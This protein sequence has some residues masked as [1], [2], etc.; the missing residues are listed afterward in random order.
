MADHR[1]IAATVK[2]WLADRIHYDYCSMRIK[3]DDED[4][5]KEYILHAHF[6]VCG[7]CDGRGSVVNPS[8]DERGLTQEDFDEDPDFRV[9]YCRGRYDVPC[10][11]CAGRNVVLV[12]DDENDPAALEAYQRIVEGAWQGAAEEAREREMG[13]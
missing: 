13:Y 4:A 10:P 3:V 6:D 1:R 12:P 5:D 7:T 11:E 9:E 2:G 8:I